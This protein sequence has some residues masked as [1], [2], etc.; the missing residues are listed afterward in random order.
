MLQSC[1]GR[2]AISHDWVD[3]FQISQSLLVR[4]ACEH[5]LQLDRFHNSCKQKFSVS[6]CPKTV[7]FGQFHNTG[8]VCSGLHVE[9]IT[10]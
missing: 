9:S 3:G 5:I 7:L 8:T 4:K 10:N 2:I 6:K 1:F